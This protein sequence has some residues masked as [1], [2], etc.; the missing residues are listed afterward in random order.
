MTW[1]SWKKYGRWFT[2]TV[3]NGRVRILGYDYGVPESATKP[4]DGERLIFSVYPDFERGYPHTLDS[5]FE[6]SAPVEYDGYT[7]RM[8]WKR[9]WR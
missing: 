5:V 6:W 1:K 7:R 4:S 3:K 9:R 8:F 2:R